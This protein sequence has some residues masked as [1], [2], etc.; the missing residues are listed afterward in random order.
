[1]VPQKEASPLLNKKI[2][3]LEL[4]LADVED[5]D[6]DLEDLEDDDEAPATPSMPQMQTPVTADQDSTAYTPSQVW[7]CDTG[8]REWGTTRA[9]S[10]AH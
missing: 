8:C 7:S 9:R 4:K 10:L 2:E 5:G 6:E 1:M 3:E